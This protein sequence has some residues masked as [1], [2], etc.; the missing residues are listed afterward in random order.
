[1]TLAQGKAS[2]L[3]RIAAGAI[4][5]A[6][7]WEKLAGGFVRGGFTEQA[8]GIAKGAW[9]AWAS[10][11]RSFVLPNAAA[12]SWLVALGELALGIALV[13]GLLTRWACAGGALLLAAIL[14]GQFWVPGRPWGDWVTAG[15]TTK[16]A[17]LLVILLAAADAGRT[18]GLDARMARGR[19]R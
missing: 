17:L 16:F 12:V 7:G 2:A 6:A 19:R 11:L 18:W 5:V 1:M 3:V 8:R 13:L 14:L 10:F 9:P 15:L 4:F